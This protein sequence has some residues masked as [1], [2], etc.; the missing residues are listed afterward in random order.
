MFWLLVLHSFGD[1]KG[2]VRMFVLVLCSSLFWGILAPPV[3]PALVNLDFSFWAQEARIFEVQLSSWP[4]GP[5]VCKEIGK[6]L[7]DRKWQRSSGSTQCISLLSRVSLCQDLVASVAVRKLGKLFAFV[8]FI[9][10]FFTGDWSATT[11]SVVVDL[12][13]HSLASFLYLT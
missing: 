2:N 10:L 12:Q 5:W 9:Q 3:P 4:P 7:D 8:N 13:K 1:L 11:S 6:C